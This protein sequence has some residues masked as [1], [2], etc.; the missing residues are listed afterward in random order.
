MR[1]EHDGVASFEGDDDLVDGA[2]GGVGGGQNGRNHANRHANFHDLFVR[3]LAQYAD[4]FH[5]A[6]GAG[7]H[8]GCQ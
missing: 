4:G 8:V 3:I 1:A 5:A 7:Q 6:N 2:R